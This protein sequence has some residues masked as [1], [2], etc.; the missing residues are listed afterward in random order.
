MFEARRISQLAAP[1]AVGAIRICAMQVSPDGRLSTYFGG[2]GG[3]P[4]TGEKGSKWAR[5]RSRSLALVGRSG[6]LANLL[7]SLP[8]T[9]KDGLG[10]DEAQD[11]D[12]DTL[13][14]RFFELGLR[15]GIAVTMFFMCLLLILSAN[16]AI[17]E[18]SG[19]YYPLFRGC[20][21]LAYF[22][23]LFGLLLFTWKRTGIDYAALLDVSPARTNY[24]AVV[25]GASTLMLLNF[26]AF[27]TFWLTCTVQLTPS[28]HIW[29][30]IAFIGT[31]V[32]LAAPVDWMPE[33]HDKEQRAALMRIV[34]K[35][36]RA[37][38]AQPSF[39]SSFVADVFT[40]MPKCFIDLL[41]ATCIYLP[42]FE[43]FNVGQWHSDKQKFDTKLHVCTAS[44]PYYRIFFMLLSLLP[45]FMR[46]MQCVRQIYDAKPFSASNKG[47]PPNHAWRQPV[48]NA[49][50]YCS[51]L[52]V[53]TLSL[54]GGRSEYWLAASVFSSCFA[55]LW[56]VFIDWGL[57]PQPLRRLVRQLLTPGAPQ[58][59]EFEDAAYWLRP[60]RVLPAEWYVF[61]IAF[62]LVARLGWA[63][64][65]SPGQQVVAQNV[66]L[67]LGALEL[68][69]RAVWA[70]FRLEWEQILRM[71]KQEHERDVYDAKLDQQLSGSF[72]GVMEAAPDE[73]SRTVPL[74]TKS[75][76]KEA[77]IEEAI[78][79]NV[80]RMQSGVW[81][82]LPPTRESAAR[83]SS[84]DGSPRSSRA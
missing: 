30:I 20:F 53:V 49:L 33:W 42:P 13:K 9:V 12:V 24:H 51:S 59:R 6:S 23:V 69:R 3:S 1:E 40:S 77:R 66:T 11:V 28:K 26:T 67:M 48:A 65:I 55:F 22:G 37:P 5:A 32:L 18:L 2:T 61:A 82:K 63:V 72:G 46:L 83:D 45:F 14:W 68:T 7:K 73:D 4:S 19:L 78:E 52:L 15:S 21:L 56:D 58:G 54:E 80:K 16:D 70:L 50:K 71:A 29:P 31:V 38:F 10:H 60:I 8:V 75:K 41:F 35:A 79:R 17:S 36:L 64:Y 76:S 27:V 74:L 57:G 62:D 47:G 44:H 81:E 25:R 43:A 39:A 84:R 34:G